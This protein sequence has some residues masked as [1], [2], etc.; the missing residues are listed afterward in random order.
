MCPPTETPAST[1]A[2]ENMKQKKMGIWAVLNWGGALNFY[3]ASGFCDWRN[4]HASAVLDLLR[5][6]GWPP[7]LQTHEITPTA[8]HC[9]SY[10]VVY[11]FLSCDQQCS[12]SGVHVN[13]VAMP[14][15]PLLSLSWSAVRHYF[16]QHESL[17]TR[18]YSYNFSFMLFTSHSTHFF[19]NGDHI[20][21]AKIKQSQSAYNNYSER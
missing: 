17:P 7:D 11:H 3:P 21:T 16:A 20:V 5:T 18:K 12:V 15:D 9:V 2:M 4:G 8:Q 13:P 14:P 6:R 10:G 19:Y 1:T